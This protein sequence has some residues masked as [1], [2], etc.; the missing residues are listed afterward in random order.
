MDGSIGND[1]S[2]CRERDRRIA[3]LEK[4]LAELEAR[5]E[6]AERAGKRQAAPFSQGPPKENPKKPGRKVGAKHGRHGHRQPPPADKIDEVHEAHLP[7]HCDCGGSVHET[8]V[9]TAYQTEIPRRVIHRQFNIHCG[10]CATCGRRHRGRHPL[11]TSDATGAAASQLGPDAQTAIVYLNK[12]A[13]LS[14]GKIA[15]VFQHFYHLKITRGA[16]AQIVL[17]GS[18]RLEPAYQEIRAKLKEAEH[19]TPDETGWRIG[20]RP[21]WLH[22]G[23]GDNGATLYAI[24]P[25]RSAE[26]LQKIIGIDWS[27]TMTHDGFSSY[28]CR[29]DDA[30]HQQC[31]DHALRRARALLEKQSPAA[32]VFSSQVIDLFGSALDLRDQFAAGVLDSALHADAYESYTDKLCELT[33]RSR[34]NAE[35]QTFA[36][37]LHNHAAEWFVFLLDPNVPATNHRAEQGL[38]TPITNRK[39]WGG[40]RTPNGAHAQEVISSVVQTCKSLATD[41]FGYIGQAFCG[42]T[43]KLFASPV[44]T[45]IA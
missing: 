7:E 6:A 16:C 17:R 12:Q 22:I 32:G 20:G 5:L 3:D 31:V 33:A 38:K 45:P 37:H 35:N 29:F 4:R 8:H 10:H 26:V 34:P 23:V 24:D 43:A 40:N 11:Q 25:Q 13:G 21:A 2:G 15:A 1:C 39:V 27:G 9:D 36:N 44:S 30:I 42:F 28:G 14:H 18:E 41:V 19:I